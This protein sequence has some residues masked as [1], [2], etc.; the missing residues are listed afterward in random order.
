MFD[1]KC[2]NNYWLYVGIAG[3]IVDEPA[4]IWVTLDAVERDGMPL[5]GQHS[6][7]KV[8][9]DEWIVRRLP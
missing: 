6:L 1:S 2:D 4:D 7:E 3:A 5:L 9:E 8:P